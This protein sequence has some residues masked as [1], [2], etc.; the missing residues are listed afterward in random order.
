MMIWNSM[1]EC[2]NSKKE[3][4]IFALFQVKH[5]FLIPIVYREIQTYCNNSNNMW[6]VLTNGVY[7]TKYSKKHL[8]KL[9]DYHKQ[10]THERLVICGMH[11][12]SPSCIQNFVNSLF[13]MAM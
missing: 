13:K 9:H 6:L 1:K 5:N 10:K 11:N 7:C 12:D 4:K 2:L 8:C 3:D